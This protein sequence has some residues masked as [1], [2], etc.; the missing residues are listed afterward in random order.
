MIKFMFNPCILLTLYSYVEL[1]LPVTKIGDVIC[2]INLPNE[3]FVYGFLW[4]EK[5]TLL[6]VEVP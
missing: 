4:G 2:D 1:F 3:L 6:L 5:K